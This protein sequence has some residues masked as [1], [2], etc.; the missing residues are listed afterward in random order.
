MNAIRQYQ[1]AEENI[2]TAAAIRARLM[3]PANAFRQPE[4]TKVL[5]IEQRAPVLRQWQKEAMSFDLHVE[6]WSRHQRR[7]NTNPYREYIRTRCAELGV[8][9][10]K[11]I[12]DSTERSITGP[13]QLLMWELRTKFGLSYP[14]I[15]REFGGKNHTTV[16]AAVKKVSALKGLDA[17]ENITDQ[18]RLERNPDLKAKLREAYEKGEPI[19]SLSRSYAISEKVIA[20]SVKL[21]GWQR[22]AAYRPTAFQSQIR[23]NMALLKQEF[24]AGKMTLIRLQ[25]RHGISERTIRRIAKANGW[26]RASR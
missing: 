2:R 12:G 21:E 3:R 13:R 4:P 18:M 15:A 5:Q 19:A 26:V 22:L 7:R 11:V 9:F 20:A 1:S 6:A 25:K 16:I 10:L 8:S 14:R 23:V 24:E 17:P